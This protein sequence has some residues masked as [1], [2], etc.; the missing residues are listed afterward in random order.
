[1]SATSPPLIGV[2]PV[3]QTPFLDDV[4]YP[5]D[6][7]TLDR[8]LSWLFK[9]GASGVT[10]AMVS[11]TLRLSSEERD[12]LAAFVCEKSAGRGAS[13]ISVGAE[14]TPL[15]LRH[16]RHAEASHLR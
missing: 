14:S 8:E 12:Q 10:M 16:A 15:T 5:I 9:R 6:Y 7:E 11:E 2:I 1:M 4:D 13:V 3:F